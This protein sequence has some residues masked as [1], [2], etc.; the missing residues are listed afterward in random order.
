MTVVPAALAGLGLILWRAQR[1]RTLPLAG[2]VALGMGLSMALWAVTV[3]A[4]A[5]SLSGG[6]P[7]WAAGLA[8]PVF[9]A[10]VAAF[11]FWRA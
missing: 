4:H 9:A 11:T 1:R 5:A 2:A 7:T 6:L 3:I 10:A 8:P